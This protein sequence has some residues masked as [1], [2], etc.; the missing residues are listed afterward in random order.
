MEVSMFGLNKY[1]IY[2]VIASVIIGAFSTF[3]LMWKHEIEVNAKLTFD[4]Q[5]L[6][7][8]LIEQAKHLEEMKQLAIDK[9]KI[10]QQINYDNTV[11]LN[12]IYNIQTYLVSEEAKKTDRKASIILKNTVKKLMESQ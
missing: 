11:L 4:K 5:Q 10:I 3:V 6:H 1:T 12:K 2:G 8:T 9:D 7:I